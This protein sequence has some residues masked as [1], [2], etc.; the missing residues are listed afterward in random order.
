[1]AGV[2]SSGG[3]RRARGEHVVRRLVAVALDGVV[4]RA[5]DP[6]PLRRYADGAA[7]AAVGLVLIWRGR[8]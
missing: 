1:M 5:M 7:L 6:D 3:W 2:R 8:R 4:M